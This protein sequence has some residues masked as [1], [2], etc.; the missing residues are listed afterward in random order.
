MNMFVGKHSSCVFLC[1]K[2]IPEI[3]NIQAI[4]YSSGHEKFDFYNC[5][6]ILSTIILNFYSHNVLVIKWYSTKVV[7]YIN[8]EKTNMFV[9]YIKNN[10]N[11]AAFCKR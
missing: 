4:Y 2:I 1:F 8:N 9:A 7:N 3:K 5:Y 6:C 11:V 10:K